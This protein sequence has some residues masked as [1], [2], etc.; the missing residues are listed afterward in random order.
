M[1]S[2]KVVQNLVASSSH[3]AQHAR[4]LQLHVP[5]EALIPSAL[6]HLE[7]SRGICRRRRRNRYNA[8]PHCTTIGIP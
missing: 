8:S 1:A 3:T 6:V 2:V 7:R 5:N 4:A